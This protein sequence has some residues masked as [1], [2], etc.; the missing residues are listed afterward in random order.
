MRKIGAIT[1]GQSPRDD[2]TKDILPILEGFELI[3]C[4]ALD[5]Y[6]YDEV[7]EKFKPRNDDLFISRMRDGRQVSLSKAKIVGE[8]NTCIEN[9]E[10]KGCEVIMVFC[11]GQIKGLKSKV[12]LL[13][14]NVIMHKLIPTLARDVKMAIVVPDIKQE[15]FICKQWEYTDLSI[16]IFA[17]SPYES[18]NNI[19]NLVKELKKGSFGLVYLDCIGYSKE[20]QLLISKEMHIPVVLPRIMLAQVASI[21]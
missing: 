12:N 6:K 4:G 3:E 5:N 17:A 16:E 15:S 19:V 11:T 8:L 10:D 2:V 20:M 21:I 1:I 18:D 9:L 14:P 13:Q 7:I